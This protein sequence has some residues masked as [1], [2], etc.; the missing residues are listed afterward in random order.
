MS[1]LKKLILMVCFLP[2]FA[3]ANA[4]TDAYIASLL[5]QMGLNI[6]HA[7]TISLNNSS[8]VVSVNTDNNET[9]ASF[10]ITTNDEDGD[11][12][13]I[14]KFIL[15][16]DGVSDVNLTNN[17]LTLTLS[18]LLNDGESKDVK[19][20]LNATDG[21]SI[22]DTIE[23]TA[24]FTNPKDAATAPTITM[25]DLAFDNSKIFIKYL[26]FNISQDSNI[27]ITNTFVEVAN[28]KLVSA[29]IKDDKIEVQRLTAD[30]NTTTLTLYATNSEGLSSKKDI[31]ISMAAINLAPLLVLETTSKVVY[32]DGGDWNTTIDYSTYDYNNDNVS[33]DDSN[34]SVVDDNINKQ[35]TLS[36]T[37][38][39]NFIFNLKANDDGS[40]NLESN[41]VK[42]NIE[43]I[44]ANIAP[45]VSLPFISI[46]NLTQGE[47]ITKAITLYDED[48]AISDL[49]ITL[50]LKSSNEILDTNSTIVTD[51]YIRVVFDKIT[52]QFN[53]TTLQ[54]NDGVEYTVEINIEDEVAEDK[55]SAS[56]TITTQG[57]NT[58]LINSLV[59]VQIKDYVTNNSCSPLY[60]YTDINMSSEDNFK[61]NYYDTSDQIAFTSFNTINDSNVSLDLSSL[62]LDYDSLA[63][64]YGA[65]LDDNSAGV[66]IQFE[67]SQAGQFNGGRMMCI[68]TDSNT[69]NLT[70]WALATPEQKNMLDEYEANY[71]Q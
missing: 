14:N 3:F 37:N 6:N 15:E 25:S 22:S 5:A 16:G 32:S 53:I 36:G 48:D 58:S 46:D 54:H 45:V 70:C 69:S 49:N 71:C 4:A 18:S 65:T 57:A 38:T 42:V 43:V 7:P 21:Q 24:T 23:L 33:I 56:F 34:I 19:I 9:T 2:I 61:I 17:T 27:S 68:Y 62:T 40:G 13:T 20:L 39:G 31:T 52:K 44:N 47:S 55:A 11:A 64:M 30:A 63:Q 12:I 41:I 1:K 50:S 10:D 67:I 8:A 51:N 66:A 59:P 26:D 60:S 29:I 28:T 35:I